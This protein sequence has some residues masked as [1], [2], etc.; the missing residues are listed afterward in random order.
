MVFLCRNPGA[1]WSPDSGHKIKPRFRAHILNQY[2][3]PESGLDFVPGIWAPKCA[4]IPAQKARKIRASGVAVVQLCCRPS[5]IRT[6]DSL[7][8]PGRDSGLSM[9]RRVQSAASSKFCGSG[10]AARSHCIKVLQAMVSRTEHTATPGNGTLSPKT[11]PR[12]RARNQD[13]ILEAVFSF[14]DPGSSRYRQLA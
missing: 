6:A 8:Q 3:S 12:I 7:S 9:S 10:R 13:L 2:I 4:R 11:V 5:P 14:L 1:F